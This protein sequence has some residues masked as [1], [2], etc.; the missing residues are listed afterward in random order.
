M[1]CILIRALFCLHIPITGFII[2]EIQIPIF[3]TTPNLVYTSPTAPFPVQT[4]T[5]YNL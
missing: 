4:V 1:H 3:M 2:I 5:F